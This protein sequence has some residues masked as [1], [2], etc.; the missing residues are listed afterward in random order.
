L[1]RQNGNYKLA[2]GVLQ[3]AVQNQTDNPKMLFDFAR[4]AYSVGKIPDAQT[5]MQSALQAGLA[6]P[7]A[8]EAENFLDLIALAANPAQ[9]VAAQTRAQKILESNSNDVPALM[10]LAIANEQKKDFPAAENIYEKILNHFPDFALA[11]KNL[12]ML[13]AADGSHL[14]RAYALATQ[15]RENFP[16]DPELTKT[17]G[18]IVFRKADYSRAATLLKTVRD[19]TDADAELFYYLGISEFRLKNF[20]ESKTSLQRALALNLSTPQAADAKEVLAK[21]K[22]N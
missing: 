2:F 5:A 4:A 9:A 19:E 16:N 6:A 20:A 11:Q 21:L 12:A 10:V 17:L 1:A 7:Q 18:V 14:D 15:A 8:D 22:S 13:Y 3:Q